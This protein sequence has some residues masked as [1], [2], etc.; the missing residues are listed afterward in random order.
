MRRL[1]FCGLLATYCLFGASPVAKVRSSEPFTLSGTTITAAG[2]E[3]WPLVLGD[4]IVTSHAPA[5]IDFSD[6]RSFYVMPNSKVTIT[7]VSGRTEAVMQQG[8]GTT[9]LA[10]PKII[11]RNSQKPPKKPPTVSPKNPGPHDGDPLPL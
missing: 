4:E 11:K 9:K 5:R 10:A 1:V 2:V 7:A 3:S 8:N 6:G